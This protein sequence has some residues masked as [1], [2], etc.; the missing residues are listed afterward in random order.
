MPSFLPSVV[1]L[2]LVAIIAAYLARTRQYPDSQLAQRVT[3]SNALALATLVQGVH[4]AEE[5]ATGFHIRFPALFGL[6]PI[7]LPLFVGFN[8]VWI[9]LWLLSIRP[10]RSAHKAAYFAAWFLALAGA[11]NGIAHPLMAVSVGAYFPGLITSP[12]IGAVGIYLWK[13]LLTSSSN[14]HFCDSRSG[15]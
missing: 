5:W 9:S 2:G 14:R 3:A 1:V 12:F 6:E 4:F 10:L 13:Q 11:L 15:A 7:S 8:L